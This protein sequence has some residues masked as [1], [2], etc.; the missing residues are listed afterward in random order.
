MNRIETPE[1]RIAAARIR[2]KCGSTLIESLFAIS[3]LATFITGAAT[4]IVMTHKLSDKAQDHYKA[5]NIA[6]NQVEQVRNLRR[7]DFEQ[8]L[9]LQEAGTR[10]DETGTANPN[11]FF[12]RVTTITRD[13]RNDYLIE[14]N[15]RVDL[16][17]RI[18]RQF[19]GEHEELQSYIAHLLN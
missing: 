11:G 5:I 1:N 13:S 7:S 14:V 2:N 3:L 16:L 19:T 12:R 6:K 4:T 18:S 8:I 15:V 9:A 17:N 10:V